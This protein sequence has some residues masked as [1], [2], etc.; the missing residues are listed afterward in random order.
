M[1]DHRSPKFSSIGCA[2]F[3]FSLEIAAHVFLWCD[4]LQSADSRKRRH[5]G[6]LLVHLVLR[7]KFG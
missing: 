4:K 5:P 2:C 1:F 6:L 7:K 3:F